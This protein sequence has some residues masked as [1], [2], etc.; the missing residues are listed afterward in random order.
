MQVKKQPKAHCCLLKI[1]IHGS[2]DASDEMEFVSYGTYSEI[3]KLAF[4][5]NKYVYPLKISLKKSL[6]S[7]Q[8][9]SLDDWLLHKS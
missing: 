4:K 6:K 2:G 5:N 3:N 1:Y 9:F 8:K 7:E